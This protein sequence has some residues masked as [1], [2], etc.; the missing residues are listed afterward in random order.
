M[1]LVDKWIQLP[2]LTLIVGSQ[3]GRTQMVIVWSQDTATIVNACRLP[4]AQILITWPW[5]PSD[6]CK[7]LFSSLWTEIK[8]MVISQGLPLYSLSSVSSC[9]RK[10]TWTRY[11]KRELVQKGTWTDATHLHKEAESCFNQ[12]KTSPMSPWFCVTINVTQIHCFTGVFQNPQD[13]C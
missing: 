4:R 6:S 7:S 9:C 2:L 11:Y 8:Q 1:H 12:F 5:G 3:L 13:G 10:G